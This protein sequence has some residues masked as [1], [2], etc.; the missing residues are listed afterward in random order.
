MPYQLSFNFKV[1]SKAIN[2]P[3]NY[4]PIQKKVVI[5]FCYIAETYT[6]NSSYR[7]KVSRE[8]LIVQIDIFKKVITPTH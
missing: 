2:S 8:T 4:L 6:T 7:R 5:K 1:P 3:L